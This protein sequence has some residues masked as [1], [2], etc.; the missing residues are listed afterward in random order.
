MVTQPT[1]NEA[2]NRMLDARAEI[3]GMLHYAKQGYSITLE[4]R[5]PRI[6]THDFNARSGGSNVAVEAKFLRLPDR[7]LEYLMRWWDAA[8]AISGT[9]PLGIAP[10]IKFRWKLIV[11]DLASDE[12]EEL[13]KLFRSIFIEPRLNKSLSSGRI[14]IEYSPDNTL[15]VTMRILGTIEQNEAHPVDLLM[16][17]MEN[18]IKDAEDQLKEAGKRGMQ[19]ACYLLVNITADIPFEFQKEYVKAENDLREKPRQHELEIVIEEARYL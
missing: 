3:R 4:P 5:Q 2:H 7:L 8:G 16:K 15:P 12:I 18:K 6:K 19:T 9:K 10:Y 14:Q 1:E 17:N 11:G 13:K